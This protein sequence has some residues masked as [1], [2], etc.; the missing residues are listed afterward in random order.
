MKIFVL[1]NAWKSTDYGGAEEFAL[2]L[3][4]ALR[5]QGVKATLISGTDSLINKAKQSKTP[6]I[7]GPYSERQILTKH[8]FIFLPKYLFDLYIGYRTY[9]KIFSSEKPD[10]IHA[11]SQQDSISATSAAAK[12]G[13]PVIWS[14]HG[15]L[16]NSVG[17]SVMPPWGVPGLLLK[18]R[19][20]NINNI[21]MVNP[22]DVKIVKSFNDSVD[23]TIIPNGVADKKTGIVGPKYDIV[24]ASRIIREK[25][26]FEL[27]EAYKNLLET[28]PE[29]SLLIAGSGPSEQQVKN[30]VERNSLTGITIKKYS[31]EAITYGGIFV[32]PTYTEAQSLAILKAMMYEK[33]IITTSIDGNIHFL[34]NNV[35][36]LLVEPKD[37]DSLFNALSLL[38]DDAKLKN[39]ISK[40]AR[41]QYEQD[42]NLDSIV[43]NNYLKL[44]YSCI[45]S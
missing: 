8:R 7:E 20:G 9:L 16:K 3:V 40:N 11:T 23:I 4:G 32:L 33:P 2:T 17:R 24:F 13:I 42:S 6:Y 15:E 35:N 21:C 14:D 30:Y 12:L 39:T 31:D 19:L 26:I 41:K 43:R 28:K 18:R 10:L 5:L 38:L 27:L 36:S 44:Y 34:K 22:Q 45:N 37:S 25:G 1:R 29:S